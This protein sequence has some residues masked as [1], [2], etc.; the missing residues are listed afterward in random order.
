MKLRKI[1]F[2]LIILIF[3]SGCFSFLDSDDKDLFSIKAKPNLLFVLDNSG[4]MGHDEVTIDDID[5]FKTY[6][7]STGLTFDYEYTESQDECIEWECSHYRCRHWYFDWTDWTWK[8]SSWECDD[9]DCVQWDSS[10]IAERYVVLRRITTEL[11][12][13]F[14]NDINMGI[15]S[16][17]YRS[18]YSPEGGRIDLTIKDLSIPTKCE[19]SNCSGSPCN[20]CENNI[21]KLFSYVNNGLLPDGNTPLAESLDTAYG[22]FK[23]EINFGD[24]N[25]WNDK[26]DNPRVCSEMDEYGNCTSSDYTSPIKWWCQ[27]NF[28]ILITDGEP[29]NDGFEN[30]SRE[31]HGY[32]EFLDSWPYDYD[33]DG[34]SNDRKEAYSDLLDDV[35]KYMYDTDLR[36]DLQDTQNIITYAVGMY[37]DNQLIADTAYNGGGEY[38]TVSNY[39]EMKDALLEAVYDII[40][41]A[42]AFTSFTAPK[43]VTSSADLVFNGYFFP[44]KTQ[45]VWEGHLKAYEMTT[46][47]YPDKDGDGEKDGNEPE[48]NTLSDC[49]NANSDSVCKEYKVF[50]SEQWEAAD[51]VP[52]PGS[53]SL[54]T[55]YNSSGL[56]EIDFTSTNAG[57]LQSL[58][59]VSSEDEAKKTINFIRGYSDISDPD[60]PSGTRDPILGDIFHSDLFFVG[61]P[62]EWKQ[63]YYPSYANFFN[64]N[65]GRDK[66]IYAGTNDGILHCIDA[67]PTNGITDGTEIWGFV[68]DEVLDTLD[69]IALND[70]H[71]YTVDG[72][73][74]VDDVY[75]RYDDGDIDID[76]WATMLFFGLRDGGRAYYALDIS[77]PQNKSFKWKFGKDNS[78]TPPAYYEWLGDT[79]CNPIIAKIKYLENSSDII[80]KDKFVVIFGGGYA[81]NAGNSNDYKGKALFI[82]DAW[83]G[84]L[85]W[86]AA[87]ND[88]DDQTKEYYLTDDDNFNYPI[89]SAVTAIDKD[90]NG[91][92]ETIYFGNTGGNLFKLDISNPDR[93][94]WTPDIFYEAN[95]ITQPIFL[96]PS[97]AFDSCYNLWVTFGTGERDDPLSSNTGRYIAI[98]DNG[99][100]SGVNIGDGDLKQFT[101]VGNELPD[102]TMEL[103]NY[104]GWYFNFPDTGEK[105]F[106]PD[107]VIM[108][109][110]DGI[111]HIYLNTYQAPE[112][113]QDDPC[114]S[115]GEMMF[116]DLTL[117][118]TGGIVSGT[119]ES[120]RISGGGTYQGKGYV[121]YVGTSE[122]G[123]TTVKETKYMKF[124]YSG[125]FVFWKERKR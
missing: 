75:Y 8:C 7:T 35:A 93:T 113:S 124:P 112:A 33:N 101:W 45:G 54:F 107:P 30:D 12:D 22:Y 10:Y 95:D 114:A 69:N 31:Y 125:G 63:A 53:R 117:N 43:K 23:G 13:V 90:N 58:L 94:T 50:G 36:D 83:T 27:K 46:V 123:S 110:D 96:A 120:G 44:K 70:E 17:F 14:R 67:D 118:C 57:D 115:G 98:I 9:W 47:W 87:Y 89:P 37:I 62:L 19:D 60:N 21:N 102:S 28:V 55:L 59:G 82:V 72:R 81:D 52:N 100:T 74:S 71:H 77:D 24:G 76:S 65:Q 16:F 104:E 34:N 122:I 68:P 73:I 25:T 39:T 86:K 42:Y 56:T 29:T 79:W 97:I 41:R 84:N 4:S 20:I 2:A 121:M 85:I 103:A 109:D 61:T 1:I 91:Y 11:L 18:S 92:V 80:A 15:E 40:Q 64:N 119:R 48:F 3:I 88:S 111:P 49:V 99:S 38:Y 108:P 78:G 5:D 51:H 66:V 6:T 32:A 26:N 116:Y 105:L 106:D